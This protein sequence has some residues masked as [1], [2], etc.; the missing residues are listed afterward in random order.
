MRSFWRLAYEL[1][2]FSFTMAF[3]IVLFVQG[4]MVMCG[5]IP[6]PGEEILSAYIMFTLA[7]ILLMWAVR[8]AEALA[9]E[10]AE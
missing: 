7:L 4:I 1:L 5:A 3:A 10:L 8:K 9:K 2:G 6:P